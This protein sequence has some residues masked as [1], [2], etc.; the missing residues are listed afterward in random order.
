AA[1]GALRVMIV[2]DGTTDLLVGDSRALAMACGV[3]LVAGLVVSIGPALWMPLDNVAIALRSDARGG[4]ATR[5]RSGARGLLLVLEGALSVT[6]L[7][8]A[9]L[10][11]RSL[12]NARHVH[13]GWS[14][15]RVL[16]V[17]P[18]YRGLQLDSARGAAVREA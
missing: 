4:A 3:A 16:N 13:L 11:V 14:A 9:G 1:W 2:R 15:E 5:D 17:T 7:V 10:F 6:L 18:N 12:E 8:G